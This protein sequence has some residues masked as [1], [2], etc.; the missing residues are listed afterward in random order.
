MQIIPGMGHL[1][2]KLLGNFYHLGEKALEVELSGNKLT[3]ENAEAAFQ[4][5]KFKDQ[6][7]QVTF[8]LSVVF[9]LRVFTNIWTDYD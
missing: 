9:F 2:W 3:F 5:L 1:L 6:G 7:L 4:A 8:D